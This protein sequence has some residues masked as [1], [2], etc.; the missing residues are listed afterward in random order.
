MRVIIAFLF[1]FSTAAQSGDF[2]AQDGWQSLES[3]QSYDSLLKSVKNATKESDM[4][5]VT[6]AGPTVAAK[7]RGIEIPGN[8]VIGIFN[9]DLAVRILALSEAAMIEAPMRLYVTENE[10][11]TADLSWKKP[12]FIL[13]PY[14]GEGGEA[15]AAIGVE[16]D[17]AFES[18]GAAAVS[19]Q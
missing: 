12:S 7:K 9:N 13:A 14:A 17:A 10:D 11:G 15:L 19:A 6:E 18:I 4:S 2:S 8:C 3:S 1:L 16:L 5:V